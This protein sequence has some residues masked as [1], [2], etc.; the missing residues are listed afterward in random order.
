MSTLS[1]Y[2]WKS[3]GK[4]QREA[5]LGFLPEIARSGV[6]DTLQGKP[7]PRCFIETSSL[8]IHIPKCA[9]SSISEALYGGYLPGHVSSLWYQQSFPEHYQSAFKFSVIRNPWDRAYSA[10]SFLRNNRETKRGSDFHDY[11]EKA[12]SFGDFLEQWLTAETAERQIHFVPQWKFISD[13]YGCI[14]VDYLCR[15]E[16]LAESFQ[17]V[18]ERLGMDV[19]F[20]MTNTSTREASYVDQYDAKSRDLVARVYARDIK[21]F[22]YQFGG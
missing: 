12:D 21:L 18:C 8:F 20:S 19:N 2:F 1:R 22:D 5:L 11:V 7:Y 10:Y 17:Y 14:N 4:N 13:R 9:G 3:L 16:N 6:V 15:H